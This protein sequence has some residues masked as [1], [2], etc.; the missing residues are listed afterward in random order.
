MNETLTTS[1]RMAAEDLQLGD[2]VALLR[3]VCEVPSFLW[4]DESHNLA[5]DEPVRIRML[6]EDNGRPLLVK[7]LCLP[8]VFVETPDG[9]CETLDLRRCELTR[10]DPEFGRIVSKQLK[11]H[12]KKLRRALLP[13]LRHKRKRKKK[14]KQ[15]KEPG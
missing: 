12:A 2:Y 6:P 7:Q 14:D 1:R 9:S 13:M 5:P 3:V 11:A 8:F 15:R 10:L 4:R